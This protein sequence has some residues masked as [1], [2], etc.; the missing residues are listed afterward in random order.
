MSVW[1][2]EY[3]ASA[4]KSSPSTSTRAHRTS[5]PTAMLSTVTVTSPTVWL[6]PTFWVRLSMRRAWF[7]LMFPPVR[8]AH[9]RANQSRRLGLATARAVPATSTTA[10]TAATSPVTGRRRLALVPFS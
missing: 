8:S 10:I 2:K 1:S 9:S 6:S 7:S 4:L 5:P 3:N